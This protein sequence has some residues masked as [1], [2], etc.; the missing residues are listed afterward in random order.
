MVAPAMIV[1]EVLDRVLF[2]A[3]A[4]VQSDTERLQLAF[5]RGIAL[6]AIIILPL[7]AVLFFLA[8]EFIYVL[9]G[10]GWDAAVAPFQILALGMLFRT[11][12]KMS[13]TLTRA[14]GAVYRRAWR[15]G[16][17]AVLVVGGAY[18]G[19]FGGLPGVALGLF[20]AITI[21]FIFMAQLSLQL[22]QLSWRDFWAA[23]VPALALAAVSGIEAWGLASLLRNWEYPPLTVLVTSSACVLLTALLLMRYSPVRFLGQDGLWMLKT[24]LAHFAAR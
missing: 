6:I 11:S 15:Q 17:Y 9:L 12:Y 23:H 10:P 5:R 4:Q 20:F 16:I 7:S 1:G 21:N 19:Q 14:I 22:A 18:V 2:P 8:P 3:M 13:D 24:L